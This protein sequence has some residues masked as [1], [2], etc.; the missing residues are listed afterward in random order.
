V[1]AVSRNTASPAAYDPFKEVSGMKYLSIDVLQVGYM[2]K[3]GDYKFSSGYP[4]HY[5]KGTAPQN[6]KRIGTA[7]LTICSAVILISRE[8]ALM[9]HM[10]PETCNLFLNKNKSKQDL[11]NDKKLPNYNTLKDRYKTLKSDSV[12]FFKELK[13]RG[14]K[15]FLAVIVMGPNQTDDNYG[16]WMAEEFFGVTN[17]EVTQVHSKSLSNAVNRKQVDICVRCA[18]ATG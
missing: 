18:Y 2:L 3:N 12:K 4:E 17:A 10:N 8:G 11:E 14:S 6:S 1:G 5:E 15:N 13:N 16:K 7:S 9:A